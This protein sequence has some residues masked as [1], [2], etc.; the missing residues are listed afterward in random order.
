MNLTIRF[1]GYGG[2]GV[3][4]AS[5]ILGLTFTQKG[6]HV[7]QTESHGAAARGGACTADLTIS[8]DPIYEL[9]FDKPSV[10][11]VL[12]TPAF[13]KCCSLSPDLS[14]DFLLIE[15]EILEEPTVKM[16]LAGLA[17]HNGTKI[18]QIGIRQIAEELGHVRY[19]GIA[20]LGA[21]A[22]VDD[23][24]DKRLL[25]KTIKIDSKLRR[26]EKQNLTALRKGGKAISLLKPQIS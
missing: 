23:R 15:S 14:S 4:T 26:F 16:G 5:R 3:V 6:F 20:S 13:R 18:Y 8:T 12:S 21:L 11:L 24:V 19:I 7:L 22:A 10:L 1:A 9:G 2:Y 17:H 25:E